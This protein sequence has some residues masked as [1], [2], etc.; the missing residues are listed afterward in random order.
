MT[1]NNHQ[2]NAPVSLD[3][4]HQIREILSK[5]AAQSDGGNLGYAMVDA[6]KVIDGAISAFGVEPVAYIF[7]HPAGRL[8]WALTDESNKWQSDVMP[9]YA[10]PPAPRFVPSELTREEY[11][12]R[13]MM[14]DNFDDTYRGGW[15]ACRSAMLQAGNSPSTPD[16]WIPVSER[17]PL[18]PYENCLYEDVEV[19][20]FTGYDVFIA[21]YAIGALPEPWGA[22]VDTAADITHWQPLAAAPQQE[23]KHG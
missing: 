12:R 18:T 16:G 23:V 5:A 11:R 9:V 17:M 4:L 19:Q 2:A 10:T 1:T 6:V 13:F 7:K 21:H 14:E 15:N 20:V 8:F 3:R 22:W